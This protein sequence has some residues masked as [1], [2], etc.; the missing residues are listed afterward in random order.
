MSQAYSLLAETIAAIEPTDEQSRATARE[1]QGSLTKPTGALGRLEMLHY[2]AAGVY[3]DPTPAVGHRL[4]VVAAGDHGVVAEGVSAY[5]QAV[6]AQMVRNMSD[7]G[8][9][10]NVLARHAGADVVVVDAG[11][12]GHVI[13][14]RVHVV[15]VGPGT[16]NMAAGP[17]MTRDEAATLVAS[18]IQFAAARAKN[19]RVVFG[20]GDMGIGNTTAA[21]AVTSVLTGAPPRA[22]TGRGTGIADH[23]FERKIRAIASAVA[24][25][26]PDASDGLHVLA[27]V[28]G[29]E[30][31]FLTGVCLGAAAA[32]APVVLD[33]YPTTA[34][35]LVAHRLAPVASEYMLASHEGA[36]P[37]HRIALEHL[38]L[39]PLLDLELRLGEGT[40]AAL[41]M[42]LLDAALRL[43]REMATFSGAGV[44]R[45]S[46]EVQPEA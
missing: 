45:S 20:L 10:I 39:Q 35:A 36:E 12:A 25:N 1:I 26:R 28:G 9:A 3:R 2:W 14:P 29:C 19:R 23:A 5:P 8:A 31:A 37:G 4:I 40:G 11:T 21:A 44:S 15:K 32:G 22:T 43:P 13:D 41:A 16:A 18:G 38:G 27:S 24:V 30:L 7:G 34:A 6:T 42:T 46:S 33:G 17:A